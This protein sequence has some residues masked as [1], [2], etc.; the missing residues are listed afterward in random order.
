[1]E[2]RNRI[3]VEGRMTCQDQQ[4][5]SPGLGQRDIADEV[6]RGLPTNHSSLDFSNT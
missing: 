3:A 6:P 1:M 4:E 5:Q 2:S